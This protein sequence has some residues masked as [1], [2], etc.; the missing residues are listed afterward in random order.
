MLGP[1]ESW[2]DG[3][4]VA[5]C[6]KFDYGSNVAVFDLVAV[7]ASMALYEISGRQFPGLCASGERRPCRTECSCWLGGP[8][9]LGYGSFW[10]TGTPWGSGGWSWSNERGDRFGCAPMSTVRL[11]GYP[12]REILQVK[13]DG[14]VLPEF[15]PITAARNWRLDRWR[16]LI[17][18]DTPA[19]P[20]STVATPNYWPSCQD[21]S[22]DSDQPGT[23]AI[24]YKWGS[25]PPSLARRAAVELAEQLFLSCP[26]MANIGCVLPAG[27]T[28]VVRQEIT[29]ERGLLANWLDVTRG[30]G[31]VSTDLFLQAYAGGQRRGRRSMIWSPDVQQFARRVGT[32]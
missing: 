4:D 32:G 19:V 14:V 1:C 21:M 27:V 7:E 5:A 15:D 26:G 10:W 16:W 28:K 20:P 6:V 11:P 22:L 12:V 29:I 30:T 8:A 9:S 3:A 31:L 17:R 13:I 23:F 2:I 25:Q 18:M 24:S